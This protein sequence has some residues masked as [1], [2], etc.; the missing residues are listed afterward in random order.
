MGPDLVIEVW[1]FDFRKNSNYI[2]FFTHLFVSLHP[3]RCEVRLHLNNEQARCIDVVALRRDSA[4]QE[5]E[6]S[7]LRSLLRRF[8][9]CI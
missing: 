9:L 8:G 3:N 6:F 1:P 7:S 5:N 2:C 4:E